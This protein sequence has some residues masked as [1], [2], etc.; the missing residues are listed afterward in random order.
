MARMRTGEFSHLI[1]WKL[2]RIS[3]NLLDFAAMYEELKQLGIT[4]VSKNE[5]FDTSSAMGEAM[6]KIILV[7]A[8]LERKVTSERV[9]SIMYSRAANGQWNGGKVPFGYDYD[10]ATKE[11]SINEREAAVVR[12]IY[13]KYEELHS[14]LAV[15]RFLNEK[16][17]TS[18]KGKH[19]N[20][21]TVGIILKNPFYIGTY[22]YNY[23]NENGGLK[24]WTIKEESEWILT[25]DHHPAIIDVDR[26]RE[27][28]MTLYKNRRSNKEGGSTY[29]RK[30]THIFAGLLKCGNCGSYFQATTDR[31]RADG[32][33]PSIYLCSRHRRFNDCDNKYISDVTLG[34]FVL[35][36][37]ANIMKAQ[38]SFGKTTSI[39]TLEKKL[40]R[41]PL[42]AD[43]EHIEGV[44]LQ[45]LYDM[46]RR[47]AVPTVEYMSK[48]VQEATEKPE[49]QERDLL[50]AERRRNE[51]ALSRLKSLFLYGEEAISEKD[52]V[53]EQ[54]RLTDAIQKIDDRL[55]EIEKNSSQHFTISDDEFITK[56]SYFIMSQKLTDKREVNYEHLIRKIDPQ[57][58]K[59]FVNSVCQN[60]CILDGRVEAIRFK[61]GMEHRFLYRS[62]E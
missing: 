47:G 16:G 44:G 27:V 24:N 18:R 56:A 59:D 48:R 1:V 46:L 8:E 54:K 50:A 60:F 39:E 30:N 29:Y 55:E 5:Q 26:W 4:F 25:E 23:R 7:F 20:P 53:I 34:P 62:P 49:A 41:G 36:Y 58:V 32:W 31:K 52:Y 43:V 51:R 2:D 19:W 35:N 40:L 15:A 12:M 14:L 13:D 6:L 3:R 21:T 37:I 28:G 10:K 9:T 38:R 11:F 22:R 57:I 61:N 42:F 33:R 45:E 17:I